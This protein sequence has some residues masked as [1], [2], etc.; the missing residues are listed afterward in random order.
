[1]LKPFYSLIFIVVV[2]IVSWISFAGC[3]AERRW[4]KVY[5][6]NDSTDLYSTHSSR[7]FKYGYACTKEESKAFYD[8]V[9]TLYDVKNGDVVAEVG[10]ASGW[11]VGMMSVF[12][13]SVTFYI[14]DIDTNYLNPDQMNKMVAYYSSLRDLPQTNKFVCV[15]GTE[16][17]TNLPDTTFDKIIF[18][19]SFHEI[20]NRMNIF[21]DVSHKLKKK[22]KMIIYDDF[23]NDYYT[24]I[25]PGC[26]LKAEKLKVEMNYMQWADL[27]LTDMAYPENSKRNFI[28]LEKNLK[29]SEQN[30]QKRKR[31]DPL[32]VEADKLNSLSVAN[33]SAKVAEIASML[34]LNIDT[35]HQTYR[36]IRDYISTIGE[37]WQTKKQYKTSLRI[38]SIN[39]ILYPESS[40]TYSDLGIAYM[41]DKQYEKAFACFSKC[42][43]LEPFDNEVKKV[44]SEIQICLKK[45][46]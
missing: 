39:L 42:S 45:K 28:T 27:Y 21:V 1:M 44:L 32:F 17:N 43:Q 46:K 13:D 23:S 34:L 6:N 19:N 16:D 26:N 35:I 12:L 29:V 4:R 7:P 33:D 2:F 18:H 36:S 25:H 3:S 31:L 41:Y 37:M 22:G 30:R 5:V 14:Q 11:I 8:E 38:Y 20:T 24:V 40:Q 15:I 10:A 9:G